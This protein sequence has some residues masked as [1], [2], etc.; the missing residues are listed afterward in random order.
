M[1][2][3]FKGSGILQI[4]HVGKKSFRISFDGSTEIRS[5][6][7][8]KEPAAEKPH[9]LDAPEFEFI[10]C[11]QI[12]HIT[13]NNGVLRGDQLAADITAL[14]DNIQKRV[15]VIEIRHHRQRLPEPRKILIP[16]LFSNQPGLQIFPPQKHVGVFQ[17]GALEPETDNHAN[18]MNRTDFQ[19]MVVRCAGRRNV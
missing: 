9:Q 1:Q 17:P 6:A 16:A 8:H 12:E 13:E 11:N 7:R 10:F 14:N 18:Q 4:F 2:I 15:P 19:Q 5:D 3:L